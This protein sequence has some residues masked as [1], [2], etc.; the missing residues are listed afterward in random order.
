MDL[1]H[2]M[3][4]DVA[5]GIQALRTTM[6]HDKGM[7]RIQKTML[8]TIEAVSMTLEKRDPYTAGHQQRVVQL[9]VAIAREMGIP[10]GRIEGLR[11]GTLVHDIGK[12]YVPA[13]ILN[14]PGRLTESEFG[15]IKSHPQVGYD[16]LKGVEFD[17]PIAE[18]VLQ[19]HER[20]DGSGYPQGL[21]GDEIM[22]EA[23]ILGVADVVEAITSHRPYRP[24]LGIEFALA[25]IE[26]GR[27]TLY[28]PS[29]ADTCLALFSQQNFSWAPVP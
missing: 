18:M 8:Q 1:L 26:K 29:V 11:L 28:D 6:A 22:L 10:E 16:I 24:G 19:H 23:R 27:G 21:R 20:C 25:E 5:Y 4:G 7:V 17:W 13:E 14:R 9:A 2:E 3:A 15:I 12:I